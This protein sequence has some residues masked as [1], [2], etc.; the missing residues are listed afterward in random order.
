MRPK[1]LYFS[2]D[3]YD[4]TAWWRTCPLAY[5]REDDFDLVDISDERKFGWPLYA[6]ATALIMQ[7]P[8]T[9][10]HLQI[11]YA[12]KYFGLRIVLDYD[13]LLDSVDMYN[14]TYQLYK[15]NLNN[16]TGCLRLADI[17]W[18]S[19][20]VI[21]ESY[22][23]FNKNCI[24]IPN[25]HNDYVFP[26]KKKI[27]FS[28]DVKAAYMRG[29]SSHQGDVNEKADLLINTIKEKED[30]NFRFMGDRYTYI[31]QRTGDNM[32]IITGLPIM[33]Y[34]RYIH[35]EK[36]SVSFFPLRDTKFN[37]AKSNIAWLEATFSGAAFYG[38][39]A[40]KEYIP[41]TVLDINNLL[42]HDMDTLKEYHDRSWSYIQENLLLSNVNQLRIES[43]RQV[44]ST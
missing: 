5:I 7:R 23:K 42:E 36:A 33:E 8:F 19:T 29:G 30:W 6:G 20:P 25:S 1:I 35:T 12:A 21:A 28:N 10:E 13:D 11:L 14:P 27:P 39:L 2:L 16:L 24:V 34:F 22:K 4:T 18:C 17:I 40:M 37:Q 41:G 3:K 32:H 15:D 31:E 44:C 43:I 38:N 9:V 26:V